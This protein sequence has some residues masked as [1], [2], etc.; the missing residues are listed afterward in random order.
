[1]SQLY[2]WLAHETGVSK[3]LFSTLEIGKTAISD[4]SATAIWVL[5]FGSGKTWNIRFW[6]VEIRAIG[7]RAIFKMVKTAFLNICSIKLAGLS[8]GSPKWSKTVK[9]CKTLGNGLITGVSFRRLRAGVRAVNPLIS[10]NF[11]VFTSN[12]D[13]PVPEPWFRVSKNRVKQWF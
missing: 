5:H 4:H 13:I 2:P 11:R 6:T 8:Y 9:K 12:T 10:G 1:M 7:I 3:Q